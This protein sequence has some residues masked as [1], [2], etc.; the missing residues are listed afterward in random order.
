MMKV[1]LDTNILLDFVD[2]R[3][4][5]EQAGRIIEEGKQGNIQLFASYLTYANMAFILRHRSRD[6]KYRLLRQARQDITVIAPT[7]EQL[8]Y[9]I[10][11][12]VRDFEDLLQYRCALDADC[13]VIVTNNT[14]DFEEFCQ[15]PYMTSED[16]V[17]NYFK[18]FLK[19]RT[20]SSGGFRAGTKATG[21]RACSGMGLPLNWRGGTVIRPAQKTTVQKY[22]EKAK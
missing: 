13:D 7:T 6:E 8:D 1:F 11:H 12:E 21:R 10:A 17:L 9:T 5:R 4:Q 19:S 18:S 22:E 15:L 14:D 20:V 2:H 16:F 3:D